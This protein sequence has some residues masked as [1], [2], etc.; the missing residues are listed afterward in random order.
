[1]PDCLDTLVG[2]SQDDCACF[3]TGR[4]S[5]YADSDSGYYLTDPEYGFP[6]VEALDQS[7]DC[8]EVG[9]WDILTA[10]R[11]QAILQFRA[12]FLAKVRDKYRRRVKTWKGTIG[13]LKSNANATGLNTY[14][15]IVLRPQKIKDGRIVLTGAWLGLTTTEGA[16]TLNISSNDPTFAPVTR[17]LSSTANQFKQTTFAT[18]QE[19]TLP[20]Y[21]D[22]VDE[23]E[24]Y[25]YFETAGLTPKQNNFY[26]CGGPGPYAQHIRYGGFTVDT[27]DDEHVSLGAN[28]AYGLALDGYFACSELEWLCD[29]DALSG[30]EVKSV[31]ARAIQ[32]NGAAIAASEV[33]NSSRINRFTT[34]DNERLA[35]QYTSLK[36]AYSNYLDWLANNFPGDASDCFECKSAR[37]FA[38]KEILV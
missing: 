19:V 17:S 21:S 9:L 5:T 28:Q 13:K 8:S 27:V 36:E 25:I 20:F 33:L 6:M 12:D 15:G 14:A 3:E 18:G 4:P 22:K 26:C 1:M 34:W 35:A 32:A 31:I 16:V 30:Y 38:R 37:N 24:Y 2:L 10:S 11:D 23:L 7:G 29:L